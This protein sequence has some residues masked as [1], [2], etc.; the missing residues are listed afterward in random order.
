MNEL[1]KLIV[2]LSL[3]GTALIL[4]LLLF[5]PLYQKR[6]SKHWQYYIW[7]VVILRLFLPITPK[8]SLTGNLFLEAEQILS[9]TTLSALLPQDNRHPPSEAIPEA[10]AAA[11]QGN[12]VQDNIIS[13]D[14]GTKSSAGDTLQFTA[15]RPDTANAADTKDIHGSSV[16]VGTLLFA[17]WLIVALLFLMRKITIY[18]SFRKYVEAGCSPLEDL[19]LLESFGRILEDNRIKGS[20]DLCTNRLV[21]SPMLIGLFRPRIILPVSHL[22]ERDFYYTI[23]HELTHYR[24][25]DMLY[26]WL[27][28][29]A[30][31]LHWFNPFV[32]LMKNEINRLCELSCDE[33]VIKTLSEASRKSYGDTLLNAVGAGGS[34]KDTLTSVTLHESKE[35]LKGRLDAI[36]Q[37]QKLSKAV[38]SAT[39]FITGLLVGSAVVLGAYAAPGSGSVQDP[40]TPNGQPSSS[41]AA[42][43]SELSSDTSRTAGQQPDAGATTDPQTSA[44]AYVDYD[45]RYED[46]IYYFH[47]GGATREDEPLS[48]VTDGYRKLVFVWK[49]HYSTFGTF[50]NKDMPHLVRNMESQCRTLLEN[51]QITQEDMDLYLLIA[52]EL[53]DSW[54]SSTTEQSDNV[55]TFKMQ[56]GYYQKPYIVELGYTNQTQTSLSQSGYHSRTVTLADRTSIPLYY[57]AAYEQPLSSD[58]A[59]MTA[60]TSVIE[61]MLAQENAGDMKVF[62]LMSL[63]YV[64]DEPPSSLARNFYEED[65]LPYF[66]AVFRVL[67]RQTKLQ[68]LDRMLTDDNISFFACCI[69]ELPDNGERKEAMEQYI[70]KA[71]EE[72]NISFFAVLSGMLEEDSRRQWLERCEKDDNIRYAII[73][74]D[75][76]I[77]DNLDAFDDL[78]ELGEPNAFDDRESLNGLNTLDQLDSLDALD[79]L[80]ALDNLDNPGALDALD[81]LDNLDTLDSLDALEKL[82]P[83]LTLGTMDLRRVTRAEVPDR[84]QAVF[85]ACKD[86]KWY[87]IET[88]DLQYIYY[89]GLP[90]TYAYESEIYAGIESGS[91]RITI[92]ITDV[93]TESPLLRRLKSSNDVL[94]AFSYAPADPDTAYELVIEYDHI[95][96]TYTRSQAK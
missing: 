72:D 75:Q 76:N 67:D 33:R 64:G 94:L 38:R 43:G 16:P 29:L 7:L 46:G 32:Y 37:Y 78:G 39:L 15:A 14:P 51:G 12:T 59:A 45:M 61:Q 18:Q 44:K 83:S 88:D 21:S 24:R 84:V 92:R 57:D 47:I 35:L 48:N 3:S 96:V 54:L 49:D 74:G 77:Y 13:D 27:V 56:G 34:Y 81:S 23:L 70:Q 4:L 30:L 53:Q 17:L 86:G 69:G 55:Y 9:G 79:A 41:S 31:C 85:D 10:E 90:G 6:L 26:K 80:N 36:M 62:I 66:S 71:Y 89:N 93:R 60:V 87:V 58:E 52:G 91:D 20:I 28:Q 42:P 68:Y 2:S 11:G 8:T 1:M 95:P 63:K 65:T 40:V 5:R 19:E 50:R 82:D 73:L 25:R 22:S